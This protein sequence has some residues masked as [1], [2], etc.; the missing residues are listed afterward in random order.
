MNEITLTLSYR[1]YVC[2]RALVDAEASLDLESKH[3]L[4]DEDVDTIGDIAA[5]LEALA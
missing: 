3:L 4:D 1:E 2:L 5:N